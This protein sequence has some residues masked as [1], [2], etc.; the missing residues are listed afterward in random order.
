MGKCGGFLGD[1]VESTVDLDSAVH[2]REAVILDL[3]YALH[4]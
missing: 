1:G 2:T 3:L 4:W